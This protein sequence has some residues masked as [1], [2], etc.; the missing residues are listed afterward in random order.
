[1]RRTA[2]IVVGRVL[3]ASAFPGSHLYSAER[4]RGCAA[5]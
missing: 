2:V 4:D 1:V 3:A 5:S